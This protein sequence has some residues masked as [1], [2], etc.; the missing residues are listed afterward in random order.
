MLYKFNPYKINYKFTNNC[1]INLTTLCQF[2]ILPNI[3][4]TNKHSYQSIS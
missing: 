1:K 3:N 4:P 2:K